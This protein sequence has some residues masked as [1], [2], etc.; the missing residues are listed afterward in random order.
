MLVGYL[1]F[2]MGVY[3]SAVKN[4]VF[5]EICFDTKKN[6]LPLP[7]LNCGVVSLRDYD[8]GGVR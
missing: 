4:W 5:I 8:L 3:I 6:I 7:R 1:Y 2:F